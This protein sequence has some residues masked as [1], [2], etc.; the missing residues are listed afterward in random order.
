M[1]QATTLAN[2]PVVY[3]SCNAAAFEGRPGDCG[4]PIQRLEAAPRDRVRGLPKGVR[5]RRAVLHPGGQLTRPT[6]GRRP[7]PMAK[8]TRSTMARARWRS[9][10]TRLRPAGPLRDGTNRTAGVKADIRSTG[11]GAR[12]TRGARA[13]VASLPATGPTELGNNDDPMSHSSIGR[14]AY[15]WISRNGQ[16]VCTA[17]DTCRVNGADIGKPSPGTPYRVFVP[18]PGLTG[19][20]PTAFCLAEQFGTQFHLYRRPISGGPAVAWA[21]VSTIDI[22]AL[23]PRRACRSMSCKNHHERR[24]PIVTLW[25]AAGTDG[26]GCLDVLIPNGTSTFVPAVKSFSKTMTRRMVTMINQPENDTFSSQSAWTTLVTP[27]PSPRY[28]ARGHMI[29]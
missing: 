16:Y 19:G 8:A 12:T 10:A 26:Y 17:F 6:D 7:S 11:L 9:S 24:C 28:K 29:W 22:T 18:S 3:M 2:V 20:T 4:V 5:G 13:D 1:N 15:E 23:T 21:W 14:Y 27:K 25:F